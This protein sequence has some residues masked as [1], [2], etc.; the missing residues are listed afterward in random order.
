MPIIMGTAG[1]IDHGKTSLVKALTGIDCDRLQEEKKRGIT[2][3]LGFAFLDLPGGIRLGVVDV[4]G[5]ERFVKNMVAGAAGIDFVVLVIAAD[6]GVMPQTREHLEI[7]TL[8]GIRRGLVALTKVDMVDEEW[9]E[10]VQEDVRAFLEPTFLGEAPVVPVSAH[11]GLGLEELRQRISALAGEFQRDSRSD[12]FRLPIDR[13]FT[14]RGHGTVATGTLVSGTLKVGDELEITPWSLKSK[15]RGLQVHGDSQERAE[16]GQRTA[17]NLHGLEVEELE[18]GMVLTHPG[19]LFPSTTWDVELT[20]LPSTPK[21]LKHRTQ[22]HFHH[23]TKET[24][25]RIYFLDRD[26]LEPGDTAMTQVRFEEPMVGMYG[27]RCVL[28]SFSPL[29]TVAGGK[30]V[31]PLG[32]KVKRFSAVVDKLAALGEALGDQ[33]ILLQLELAGLSGLTFAQLRALTCLD[34]KELEKLLQTLGG[35]QDAF[36]FERDNRTYVHGRLVQELCAGIVEFT[37]DFHRREPMKQGISRSALASGWGRKL[38]PKLFHFVLE[39]TQKQGELTADGD[40]FRL[41]THK[42]SLASD[43]AKLR[44]AILDAFRKGGVTPPNVKDVLAP[45]DLE[46]KDAAPVFRLLQ[47]QG[48]LVK[49]K[50]DMFF[51]TEAMNQLK[52]MIRDF[53][54][55]KEEMEPSDFKTVTGL[56]RKFSIPLLE[57]LDKEKMTVRVGDKRRLRSGG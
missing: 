11:K 33:R 48:E 21:A 1:H 51:T 50:E 25:A 54:R 53:F 38:H 7:C 5:H 9:L 56:T 52:G 22:I 27:D 31:N 19:S 26:K 34:T 15:V 10:L 2:I 29:R 45:L 12:V 39:R 32:R 28:R 18:R 36:L 23:G 42:V 35:R 44:S 13:I 41:P 17:V 24:L 16:V 37:A 46:M 49:V 43:Q 14:M 55:D 30:V 6:E 57:Y 4:P 8:L 3:E 47:E 20:C 40:L